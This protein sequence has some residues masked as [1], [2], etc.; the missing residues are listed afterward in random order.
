MPDFTTSYRQFHLLVAP[1][2]TF[3]SEAIKTHNSDY[4]ARKFKTRHHF[5]LSIFAHLAGSESANAL[6]EELNDFSQPGQSRNL[7]Y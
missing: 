5:L 1:L 6:L 3:L 7:G 2:L 4:R